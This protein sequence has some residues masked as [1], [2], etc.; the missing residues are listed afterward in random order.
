[1]SIYRRTY[2]GIDGK[3]PIEHIRGRRGRDLMA[4]FAE[5]ILY[6]PLR[7]DVGDKRNAK[8]NLEPRFLNG[9]FLGLTDR[10]DEIIVYGAEGIRK[11]RTIK[12]RPE[13]EMWR[14]EE[15]LAVT[16][17]PLQPNPSSEDTRIR[18]KMNP[19]VASSEVVPCPLKEKALD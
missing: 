18:T 3:T 17:T 10:S 5:S 7:G 13:E 19:G 12:R 8:A 16:G 9:I 11:A 4:E 2:V 6:I 15:V 1:M 14:K